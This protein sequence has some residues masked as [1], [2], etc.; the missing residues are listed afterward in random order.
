MPIS[1]IKDQPNDCYGRAKEKTEMLQSSNST[2]NEL[3]QR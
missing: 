2:I 3:Q 1:T